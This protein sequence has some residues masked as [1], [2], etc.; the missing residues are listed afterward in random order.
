LSFK[1]VFSVPRTDLYAVSKAGFFSS[2]NLI[3]L[4][5]N[6]TFYNIK[7]ENYN[8]FRGTSFVE[9]KKS[10]ILDNYNTYR[11]EI[12]QAGTIGGASE[13]PGFY[14]LTKNLKII[15]PLNCSNMKT[16]DPSYQYCME[17]RVKVCFK[18]CCNI[19]EI[20][21]E[22]YFDMVNLCNL[23]FARYNEEE[24]FCTD[25]SSP[26]A[27]IFIAYTCDPKHY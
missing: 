17:N 5:P 15:A 16:S 27:L 9:M 11:I 22:K 12:L 6:D 23:N 14:A 10:F 3:Q 24:P 7:T 18:E 20:P 13:E 4:L 1:T 2:T 8:Y 25:D 19:L 21:C 26:Y